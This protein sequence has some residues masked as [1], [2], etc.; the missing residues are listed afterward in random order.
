MGQASASSAST[1]AINSSGGNLSVNQPNV[2][3]WVIVGV[4]IVAFV[5]WRKK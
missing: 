2:F 4:A 1:A 5:I 3:M